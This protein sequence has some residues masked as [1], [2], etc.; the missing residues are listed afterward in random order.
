MIRFPADIHHGQVFSHMVVA[1]VQH[2]HTQRKLPFCFNAYPSAES[3]YQRGIYH[4][5]H[6]HCGS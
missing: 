4:I 5:S 2:G 3:L 6:G 1:A